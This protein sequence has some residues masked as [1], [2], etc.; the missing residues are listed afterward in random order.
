MGRRLSDDGHA[1]SHSE[2]GLPVTKT[3]FQ[4]KLEDLINFESMENGSN[5]PDL[6]LARYL[7]SC[8]K[9]FDAATRSRDDWYN[10]RGKGE[11]Q[12]GTG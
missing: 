9:A 6:I 4:S 11:S 1:S 2:M 7:V 12:E 8:L 5:T 3:L 10:E